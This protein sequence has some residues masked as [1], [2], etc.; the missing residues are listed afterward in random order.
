MHGEEL[1]CSHYACRS[2]GV[3][4]KYCSHCKKPVAKQSFCQRHQHDCEPDWKTDS[5]DETPS[6]SD[7]LSDKPS[8]KKAHATTLFKPVKEVEAVDL[9]LDKSASEAMDAN[10]GVVESKP[11]KQVKAIHQSLNKAVPAKRD[12][13][14]RDWASIYYPEK[15]EDNKTDRSG[16]RW[17][18][19]FTSSSAESNNLPMK[20]DGHDCHSQQQQIIL[21][22][23]E[24]HRAAQWAKLRTTRPPADDV[25]A[26]ESWL[27]KVI[28]MSEVGTP[29]KD[30]EKEGGNLE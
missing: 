30:Q 16:E 17:R 24:I 7:K 27:K 20:S 19:S 22:A 10:M 4:F 3:K 26:M 1:I 21:R 2:E 5:G 15:V 11:V 6:S 14:K 29:V 13:N 28:Y 8:A 23:I 12:N 9:L 25:N 18:S